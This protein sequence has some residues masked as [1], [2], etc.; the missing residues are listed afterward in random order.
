MKNYIKNQVQPME[1]WVEG[2]DLHGVSI[3][4]EDELNGSPLQGDMIAV[5]I[6]NPDDK[7]LVAAQF[8]SDNY[9]EVKS[10][11]VCH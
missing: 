9:V 10:T 11:E 2:M 4:A 1:P 6:N 3:S 8:F 7:W 5:N